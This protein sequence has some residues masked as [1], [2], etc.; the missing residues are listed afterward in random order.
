MNSSFPA[1]NQILL[2]WY[3]SATNSVSCPSQNQAPSWLL[4]SLSPLSSKQSPVMSTISCQL[5]P[6]NHQSC[7]LLSILFATACPP[8]EALSSFTW[9]AA[10]PSSSHPFP[11]QQ[12]DGPFKTQTRPCDFLFTSQLFSESSPIIRTWLTRLFM[13]FLALAH[14]FAF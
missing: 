12:P 14:H 2:P 5:C 6:V 8:G 1:A 9:N 7:P 11:H 10:K 3:L 13:T 4:V